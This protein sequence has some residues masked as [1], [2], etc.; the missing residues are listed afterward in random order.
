MLLALSLAGQAAL[1]GASSGA[2]LATTRWAK[3][4]CAGCVELNP[5]GGTAVKVAT[6]AAVL[7]VVVALERRGEH[8]AAIVAT[9][10]W[11]AINLAAATNNAV[12]AIRR[13]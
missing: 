10:C 11:T 8:K 7:G 5:V 13:R 6:T 4:R 9:L 12:H 2:D 1:I 3:D